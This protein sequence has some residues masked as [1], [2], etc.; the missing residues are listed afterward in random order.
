MSAPYATPVT[1]APGTSITITSSNDAS[2]DAFGRARSSRPETVFDSKQ[3]FDNQ[4]LLWDDAEV[5]GGSTTS[6]HSALTASSTLGVALNTAGRR[7]RQTFMRFNYQPGRS[8]LILMTGVLDESGGGTDIRRGI[9]MYDDDNGIFFEDDAGVVSCVIRSNA[10]GTPVNNAV[11]QSSWNLDTMDG[12]GPSGITLDFT[13]V[14]IFLFDFEWLGVGRVRMGFNVD[15]ITYYCHQ[16]VH[17]NVIGNVYMSTPNLPLR[18]EIENAGTG[19]ASELQTICSCVLTEGGSVTPTGLLFSV[20]HSSSLINANTVGTTYALVGIR[21]K[22]ANIGATIQIESISV[23][24][25]NN[26]DFL[27][28]LLLNPTVAGTFTYSSITNSSCEEALG[29]TAGNPSTNT[30]TGGTV[31]RSGY[32]RGNWS[33]D[34]GLAKNSI[35]LGAS[36]AGVV[37]ELV[38]CVRPATANLDAYGALSFREI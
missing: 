29:D 25:G 16:F 31:L 14:Q 28:L 6:T 13:M 2:T 9:G 24:A 18:Y 32:L 3:I 10:T 21:L 12:A 7:V 30:V 35:R 20:N 34:T 8:Q 17:A 36:I 38:L 11:A 26:Q 33:E 23:M 19:A 27:W 5:S 15:G 22:A 1:N 37:D 4:P